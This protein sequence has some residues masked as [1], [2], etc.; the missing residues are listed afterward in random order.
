MITVA[1]LVGVVIMVGILMFFKLKSGGRG[2]NA[3][4]TPAGAPPEA[5]APE[6]RAI[7]ED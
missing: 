2:N 4:G 5:T 6:P 1:L 7:G 3:A